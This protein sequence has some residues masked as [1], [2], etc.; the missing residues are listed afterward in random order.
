[1]RS[2]EKA[3]AAT[4]Q[5][6]KYFGIAAGAAAVGGAALLTKRAMQNIDQISKMSDELQISTEALSGLDHATK[7]TGAS[8]SSLH[9]G[10]Q[11]MVRRLGEAAEGYGE[12]KKGLDAMG[13]SAEEMIKLG[14]EGAFL[15]IADAVS[16]AKT[17]AEKANIAYQMLGRGGVDLL[18]LLNLGSGGL[19][20][21]ID[22]AERLGIT[23]SRDMGARVEAANDAI[24]RM[25]AA[26][27]GVGNTL[28]IAVAPYIE[29][30][31]TKIAD[32]VSGQNSIEM[33][34][35]RLQRVAK[36]GTKLANI[37]NLVRSVINSIV[38][39]GQKLAQY[40]AR[41]GVIIADVGSSIADALGMEKTSSGIKKFADDLDALQKDFGKAAADNWNQAKDQFMS[42]V[43]DET[44]KQLDA[45]LA[46]IVRKSKE[47]SK[48]AGMEFGTDFNSE[49]NKTNEK[50]KTG[51]AQ[52]FRSQYISLAGLQSK[53]D[54]NTP[55][56]REML[57][58]QRK[59]FN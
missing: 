29:V 37:F 54:P 58:I 35:L 20:Q 16:E 4:F 33:M 2:L 1:M 22:E 6:I 21:M 49:L 59:A 19:K 48:L 52:V 45:L 38:A 7:I 25:N 50:E 42:F 9:K 36:I 17:A 55:I 51:E 40:Y 39:L 57:S 12:G 5:K 53:Q 34:E 47:A 26:F 43:T 8:M 23:F 27:A 24:T 13:I 56:L 31:Q 11:I 30:I 28:A 15:K 10:L 44:G 32:I 14:T 3:T 46:D 41:V 18:N